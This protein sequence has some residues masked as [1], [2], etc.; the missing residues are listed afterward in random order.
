MPRSFAPALAVLTL[1]LASLVAS[2]E[3]AAGPPDATSGHPTKLPAAPPGKTWKLV[4]DD[5]FDG[6]VLDSRKWE[7][8][9]EA[10]RQDGL[11]SPRSI[12][13]DGKGHLL[14]ETRKEGKDYLSGCVRTRGIYEHAFG[15][16][17][18]RCKMQAQPGFWSAFWMYS[19]EV[20][21]I[22]DAGRDGTEIDIFEKPSLDDWTEHSLHWDGY[23]KVHRQAGKK[24]EVP[25]IMKG[26][27]TFGL[28]W[29]PDEYVFYVDGKETWRTRAGGVCQVPVYLKLSTEIGD[30]AGDIKKAKLPD[31]FAVDY[32]R[33]FDLVDVKKP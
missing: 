20:G 27:H 6:D 14:I 10:P 13:L 1:S 18:A 5:E 9:P 8:P 22:G 31:A 15:Y 21:H 12:R 26:F 16:Y 24:V 23:G 33:V 19:P 4:W 7:I 29:S 30:W 25:G 17:E 32:V 3:S 11:W 2:S 28:W